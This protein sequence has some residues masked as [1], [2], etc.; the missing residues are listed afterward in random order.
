MLE[1]ILLAFVL[2]FANAGEYFFVYCLALV[3]AGEYF[4]G[5]CLA[6]SDCLRKFC[7]LFSFF[8]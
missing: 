1:N 8:L 3:N 6:I 2:P 5:Y 7:W 4:V